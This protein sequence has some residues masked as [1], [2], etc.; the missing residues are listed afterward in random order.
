M[1]TAGGRARSLASDVTIS[2]LIPR[3]VFTTAMAF[4][5]LF[6]DSALG[7]PSWVYQWMNVYRSVIESAIWARGDELTL[8]FRRKALAQP[9]PNIFPQRGLS[10]CG[11]SSYHVRRPLCSRGRGELKGRIFIPPKTCSCKLQPTVSLMLA[12]GECKR[13]EWFRLLP[14]YF[15]LCCWIWHHFHYGFYRSAITPICSYRATK[16]KWSENSGF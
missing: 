13:K 3:W 11:L 8:L 7:R 12:L 2:P 15:F 1:Y 10:A 9:I 16:M 6:S 5:Q 14:N 4:H